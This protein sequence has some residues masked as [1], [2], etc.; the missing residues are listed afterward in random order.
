[1]LYFGAYYLIVTMMLI[2]LSVFL[3][4]LSVKHDSN[5]SLF[6]SWL[7]ITPITYYSFKIEF[8]IIFIGAALWQLFLFIH[9]VRNLF[10]KRKD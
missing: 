2:V 6:M 1:M 7:M 8:Y 9:L 4:Y 5:S 3:L 10:W